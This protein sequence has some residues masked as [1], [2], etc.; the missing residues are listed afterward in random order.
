MTGQTKVEQ[1]A[2]PDDDGLIDQHLGK[3]DG[4][5][6]VRSISIPKKKKK[7]KKGVCVLRL[8]SSLP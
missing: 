2:P 6:W 3:L 4:G 1:G 7:L 5:H 8:K